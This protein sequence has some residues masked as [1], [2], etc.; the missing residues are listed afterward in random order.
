MQRMESMSDKIS[1]ALCDESQNLTMRNLFSP[2]SLV[3]TTKDIFVWVGE[4]VNKGELSSVNAG[5]R[6]IVVESNGAA[7]GFYEHEFVMFS[8]GVA[9]Y[10]PRRWLIVM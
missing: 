7:Y 5:A 8:E 2:G 10:A 9:G 6:G 3:E 1:H 4:T